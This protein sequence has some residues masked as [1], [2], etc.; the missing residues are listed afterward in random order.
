MGRPVSS[1]FS[2]AARHSKPRRGNATACRSGLRQ[3]RHC[4]P[5]SGASSDGFSGGKHLLPNREAAQRK[6]LRRPFGWASEQ[7]RTSPPPAEVFAAVKLP[8]QLEVSFR[9]N[10]ASKT[11]YSFLHS[12]WI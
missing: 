11:S 8:E 9:A 7:T 4:D 6:D 1:P 5:S 12:P 2:A 10:W 3:S